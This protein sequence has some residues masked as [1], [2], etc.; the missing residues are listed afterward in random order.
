MNRPI[1]NVFD[2]WPRGPWKLKAI[3]GGNPDAKQNGQTSDHEVYV[4]V[5]VCEPITL[6][7][8]IFGSGNGKQGFYRNQTMNF[9]MNMASTAHRAWRCACAL[10]N[11]DVAMNY[12]KEA[13]IERLEESLI[14][15][16]LDAP[17]IR[18]AN[19]P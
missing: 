17:P 9:Q 18:P 15:S 4:Q 2:P 11:D 6:S 10:F 16:I 8:L 5:D 13:S 7:L 1:G 3:Y 19:A 12:S 14:L